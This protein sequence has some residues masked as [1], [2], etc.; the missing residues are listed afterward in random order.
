MLSIDIIRSIIFNREFCYVSWY[1]CSNSDLPPVRRDETSCRREGRQER[2]NNPTEIVLWWVPKPIPPIRRRH[3]VTV[4]KRRT[5]TAFY[6]RY[7]HQGHRRPRRRQHRRRRKRRRTCSANRLSR[8][9]RRRGTT[10]RTQYIRGTAQW[11]R[12]ILYPRSSDLNMRRRRVR[13]RPSSSSKRSIS[14]GIYPRCCVCHGVI[15]YDSSS[16]AGQNSSS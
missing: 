9:K 1:L 4:Q 12:Y 5:T 8:K 3:S 10:N 6:I 11:G 15:A 2:T 7:Y 13:T 16:T 14:S